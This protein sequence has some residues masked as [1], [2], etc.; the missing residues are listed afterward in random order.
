ME[1]IYRTLDK[2]YIKFG[3]RTIRVIIDDDDE[4]WFNA[5]DTA[6]TLGYARPK[7]TIQQMV[8]S[9]D[10]IYSSNIVTKIKIKSHPMTI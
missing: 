3:N 7:E 8:N 10:K 6:E 5:N 2:N 1:E 9:D 4:A